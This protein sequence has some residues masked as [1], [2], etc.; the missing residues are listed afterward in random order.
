MSTQNTIHIK[1][2]NNMYYITTKKT[3]YTLGK[4]V[5]FLDFSGKKI[6]LIKPLNLFTHLPETYYNVSNFCIFVF[7]MGQ[8]HKNKDKLT[9]F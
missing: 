7:E 5:D 9:C 1:F 2:L 3:K 6:H 8:V 4:K